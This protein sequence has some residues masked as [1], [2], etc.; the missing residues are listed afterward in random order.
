MLVQILKRKSTQDTLKV[1]KYL[2]KSKEKNQ[3]NSM[4][5]QLTELLNF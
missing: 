4:Q 3:E 1:P 5:M 2:M